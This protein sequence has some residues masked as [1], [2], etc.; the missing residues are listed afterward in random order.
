MKG[1]QG[2]LAERLTAMLA[3]YRAGRAYREQG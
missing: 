3:A 1:S 2:L